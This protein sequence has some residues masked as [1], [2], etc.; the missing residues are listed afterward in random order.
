[1]AK[2]V[3]AK[4]LSILANTTRYLTLTCVLILKYAS[5]LRIVFT[6]NES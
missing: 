2:L 1:M 6:L 4:R 3:W 5:H